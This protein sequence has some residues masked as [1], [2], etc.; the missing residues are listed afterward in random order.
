M[1]VL[2]A[3][4]SIN[5]SPESILTVDPQRVETLQTP[6]R[7]FKRRAGLG[8]FWQ[9]AR[10]KVEWNFQPYYFY[11]P[12]KWRV[13]ARSMTSSRRMMPSFASIGAVRSGTSFLSSYI[14]Q[15]PHMVL[16]LAKEISF[17][18]TMRELMAY[19]PSHSAQRAAQREN[20]GAI[21]GYCTPIMPNLLWIFLAKSMFPNLR[22]VVVLR[23]PVERVFSHW[24]WDQQ[25]S[26]SH[27]IV[28]PL[29]KGIPDFE[30]IVETEQ[31]AI[32]GG[33]IGIPAFSGVRTGYLQHSIY[34]PFL[35]VLLAEFGKERVFI[36][37]AAELFR[38]PQCVTKRIYS[39]LGVPPVEPLVIEERNSG[40]PGVLADATRSR[41]IEF[42]RPYNE[43]LYRL[44]GKDFGWGAL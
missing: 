13:L 1:T 7:E 6:Y 11:K 22:V 9:T 10:S 27:K 18:A 3:D 28:D 26:I 16:P 32:R 35:R 25:R 42:F 37:D 23:D 17:P 20:G 5:N 8:G 30:T 34:A 33:G 38:D 44:L 40:P 24:R 43:D 19:F 14:F 15:H 36:V 12:P 41:L 39:F 31:E 4:T 29:W 2:P 21:T